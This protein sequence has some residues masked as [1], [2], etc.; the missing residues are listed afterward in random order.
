MALPAEKINTNAAPVIQE[1]ERKKQQQPQLKNITPDSQRYTQTEENRLSKIIW[2]V[3]LCTVVLI[4]SIAVY[5]HFRGVSESLDS[6]LTAANE[7]IFDA[8]ENYNEVNSVLQK[9]ITPDKI[10][11]Y[12]E[13]NGWVKI[14]DSSKNYAS[15]DQKNKLEIAAAE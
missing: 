13:K 12:A 5:M 11:A 14:P 3:L 7:L 6:K 8:E 15:G 9:M 10:A 1:P 4:C 2:S